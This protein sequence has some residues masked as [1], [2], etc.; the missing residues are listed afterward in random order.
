[1]NESVA[2]LADSTLTQLRA[3]RSGKA[4]RPD[5]S[6]S[7]GAPA[8]ATERVGKLVQRCFDQAGVP[9]VHG[10]TGPDGFSRARFRRALQEACGGIRGIVD[11]QLAE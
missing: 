9:D 3:V 8:R 6:A 7:S 1:M 4:M 2:L 10:R 5:D 11:R